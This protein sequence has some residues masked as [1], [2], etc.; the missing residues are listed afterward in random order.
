VLGGES[1]AR[2]S[3]RCRRQ[4]GGGCGHWLASS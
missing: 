4:S 1:S 2:G 3:W